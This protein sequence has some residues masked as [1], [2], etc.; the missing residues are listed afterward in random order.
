MSL[1]HSDAK[2]AVPA[3]LVAKSEAVTA[4][5]LLLSPWEPDPV[6]PLTALGLGMGGKPLAEVDGGLLEHLRRD[7]VPPHKAYDLLGNGSI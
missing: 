4:A 3:L 1:T 7:L 5:A 6:L 2:A